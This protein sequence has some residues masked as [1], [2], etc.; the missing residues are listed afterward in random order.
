MTTR[1]AQFMLG[2]IKQLVTRKENM[3]K[4]RN[5]N[6]KTV[7]DKEKRQKPM[8]APDFGL[9]KLNKGYIF[10]CSVYAF[11]TI[12]SKLRINVR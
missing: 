12:L 5:Y 11:D 4:N 1:E 10:H 8:L 7:T 6:T 3:R 9:Q 2:E